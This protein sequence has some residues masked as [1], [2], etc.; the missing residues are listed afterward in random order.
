MIRQFSLLTLFIV[1]FSC[2]DSAT[3]TDG[4][5]LADTATVSEVA[6]APETAAMVKDKIETTAEANPELLEAAKISKAEVKTE[7][8][9]PVKTEAVT[10]APKA[11]KPAAA[12]TVSKSTAP[13][14]PV[15]APA[16]PPAPSTAAKT[17]PTPPSAPAVASAPVAAPEAP[18]PPAKPDHSSFNILL[19]KHVNSKGDVNYSGF[20]GD[21]AKLDAYIAQ[22]SKTSP[23]SDWG[24]NESM[25]YWINAYNANTIKL[26]LKNY[27]LKS[28]TDLNGGKPWD[29]KWI[30]IGDKTYSLNNI[31]NDIIRPRY[32]D[33]RIHFAVNC[34]AASCPP[35]ANKAFTASNL[36]SLLNSRAK[37][38]IND[39]SYNTITADKVMVSKIFD[40]Y[41]KDF[42]DLRGYLN[43]YSSFEIPAGTAIEFTEYNWSL[44]KQ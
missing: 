5:V 12:K 23:G 39:A 40:W 43:K 16:A 30:K 10:S 38:F 4:V 27:P 9:V 25:A 2:G 28:I 13:K 36:N 20:K 42:G 19:G 41:G 15:T 11:A 26:I 17:A 22:L 8:A 35:L 37:S 18:A 7:A 21:E 14:A 29:Q 31:E 6:T 32:K 3:K 34:A 24:R 33:G 44:N 1:L